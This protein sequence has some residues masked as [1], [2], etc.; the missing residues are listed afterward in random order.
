MLLIIPVVVLPN[1]G[2]LLKVAPEAVPP[3][4]PDVCK[5][6]ENNIELADD[7]VPLGKIATA[8]PVISRLPT[9]VVAATKFLLP[10]PVR[11]KLP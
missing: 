4:L 6:P 8:E 11:T 7:S 9:I 3:Q 2:A 1:L 5:T 10:E